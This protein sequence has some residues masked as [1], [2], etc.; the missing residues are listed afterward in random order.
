MILSV[1]KQYNKVLHEDVESLS[2]EGQI[3]TQYWA[4]CSW[5]FLSRE[6]GVCDIKR[7]EEAWGRAYRSATSWMEIVERWGIGFYSKVTVVG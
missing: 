4:A 2:L 7:E 1:L 3:S 5:S 6:V